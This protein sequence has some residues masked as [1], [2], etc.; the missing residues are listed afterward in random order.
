MR[1]RWLLPLAILF[2][3]LHFIALTA[4]SDLRN[5]QW[6]EK[7]R[8]QPAPGKYELAGQIANVLLFPGSMGGCLIAFPVIILLNSLLWG[9]ALAWLT[10]LLVL[11]IRKR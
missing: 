5:S 11:M 1:K 4:A 6:T 7:G 9:L 8:R 2:A 3:I 10:R